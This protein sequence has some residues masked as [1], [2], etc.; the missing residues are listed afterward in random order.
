MVS[1]Q[2]SIGMASADRMEKAVHTMLV[3][4]GDKREAFAQGSNS[5]D[6]SAEAQR[7]KAVAIHASAL[8]DRWIA[9]RNLSSG[10]ALRR[11]VGSQ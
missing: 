4:A 10:G 5:D 11:P 1:I 3:I 7:A 8:A 2:R 6:L 9:S